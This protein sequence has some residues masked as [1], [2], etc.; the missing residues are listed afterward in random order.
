M[1][2]EFQGM[3]RDP[4]SYRDERLNDLIRQRQA[5]STMGGSMN[6][7]YGQVAAQGGLMGQMMAEGLGSALGMQTR[8][9]AQAQKVQDMAK[10]IDMN[11]PEDL[12]QFAMALNDMGMTKQAL[13][14]LEK[15]Q[16]V[17]DQ[18]AREE[19]R[20]DRQKDRDRLIAKGDIRERKETIMVPMLDSKG[21]PVLDPITGEVVKQPKTSFYTEIW[22]EDKQVWEREGGA[23]NTATAPTGSPFRN[24]QEGFDKL[25]KGA[26]GQR[27]TN[28]PEL[29][30]EEY[31]KT[32]Y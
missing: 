30:A 8:E 27:F 22:N 12:N 14:V 2:N 20:A 21:R 7:L 16:S 23:A 29:T 15:R 24:L 13:M 17:L 32:R 4:R 10:M 9:E 5:I 26:E 19:D 1:A 18:Q 3:F 6:D 25:Y 31:I 11:A 28:Q